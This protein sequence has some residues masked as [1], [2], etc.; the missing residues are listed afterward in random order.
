MLILSAPIGF[1][2]PRNL[3]SLKDVIETTFVRAEI[4]PNSLSR[5]DKAV[6]KGDKSI[7][8]VEMYD[9]LSSIGKRQIISS[10]DGLGAAV[11]SLKANDAAITEN[12][13]NR[14]WDYKIG[15]LPDGKDVGVRIKASEIDRGGY[16]LTT[17][18]YLEDR[19][20]GEIQPLGGVTIHRWGMPY[21]VN[22]LGTT[23]HGASVAEDVQSFIKALRVYE[24]KDRYVAFFAAQEDLG[25]KYG[26]IHYFRIFVIPKAKKGEEGWFEPYYI[27]WDVQGV[28]EKLKFVD[29]KFAVGYDGRK[30]YFTVVVGVGDG[31]KGYSSV[32]VVDQ[33][34]KRLYSIVSSLNW[35]WSPSKDIEYVILSAR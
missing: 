17:Y 34:N 25:K 22:A 29:E 9:I 3:S 5:V 10:V 13:V 19:S 30:F 24:F 15:S 23:L 16:L 11:D 6:I 2:V 35:D 14:V 18:L 32:G 33:K 31:K 12:S 4:T 7:R 8:L 21:Q 27:S 20:T 1:S 28:K 26:Y